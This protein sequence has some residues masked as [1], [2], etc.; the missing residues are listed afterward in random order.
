MALGP[1]RPQG[2]QH[3]SPAAEMSG[4]G[5]S[6]GACPCEVWASGQ[7]Q[8]LGTALKEPR[9]FHKVSR[10]DQFFPVFL[11]FLFFKLHCCDACWSSVL[12][13]LRARQ[14]F[15]RVLCFVTRRLSDRPEPLGAKETVELSPRGVGFCV[16]VCPRPRIAIAFLQPA[17]I[18]SRYIRY[19]NPWLR[20]KRAYDEILP[21]LCCLSL[22]PDTDVRL[23]NDR[24]GAFR[25][26]ATVARGRP[27][28]PPPNSPR[29]PL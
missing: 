20:G 4:T 3:A 21:P 27:R 9:R 13:P 18:F 19:R 15:C 24:S 2:A 16:R 5:P 7:R 14:R 28:R 29:R 11:K 1:E 23:A 17:P 10:D 8:S 6:G 12:T 25:G 22:Q 26:A